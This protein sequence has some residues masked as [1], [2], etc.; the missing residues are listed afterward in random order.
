MRELRE[1]DEDDVTDLCVD[2]HDGEDYVPHVF[3]QWCCNP[4]IYPLGLELDGKIVAVVAVVMIDEGTA[5]AEG[6][7]VHR[8]VRGGWLSTSSLF[9]RNLTVG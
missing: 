6:L 8:N 4:N 2:V 7:R 1:D 5:F 3:L 9:F